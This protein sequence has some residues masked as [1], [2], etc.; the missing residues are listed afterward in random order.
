MRTHE[1]GAAIRSRRRER[2]WTLEELARRAGTSAPTVHRYESGWRRFEVHTLEKLAAALGC[3]LELRICDAGVEPAAAD[4]S[5]LARRLRRLFWDRRLR[6]A[7]LDRYPEWVLRRA[8]EYGSL[9]DVRSLVAYYGRDRFLE[10]VSAVRFES[11]R[12]RTFWREMLRLEG[13]GCTTR[14]SREEADGSWMP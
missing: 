2:G 13:L 9:D 1:I 14:F 3:R 6:A 5:T 4:R 8:L 7:D 12:T 11:G 10:L